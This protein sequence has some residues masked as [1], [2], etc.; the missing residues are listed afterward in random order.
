MYLVAIAIAI[1]ISSMVIQKFGNA[2]LGVKLNR[3]L[4]KCSNDSFPHIAFHKALLKV[5][6]V[7]KS[8]AAS[9]YLD[10]I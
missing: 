9:C 3:T 4:L 8:R 2:S 7:S 10:N 6:F 5:C 1:A